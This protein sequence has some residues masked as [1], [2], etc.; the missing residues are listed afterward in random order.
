LP[1]PSTVP[2]APRADMEERAKRLPIL[3]TGA[4]G[5]IGVRLSALLLEAGYT[6]LVFHYREHAEPIAE[7][8]ARHGL[9]PKQSLFR[10]DLTDEREVAAM[11]EQIRHT[12][13]ALY[14]L[15]NLAG[16]SGNAMSW[17]LPVSEFR[18]IVDANLLTTFICCREFIPEMREKGTGRILNISSVVGFTGVAGAVHYC[19]AKAGVVGLTKALALELAPKRVNASVIALGY[20]DVG[21]IETISPADQAPILAKIPAGRFGNMQELAGLVRYLLSDVGTYASGQVYHLNGG[22]YG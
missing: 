3:I 9:D 7:L 14:G 10:A 8:L 4:G 12:R 13:G 5:G 1:D 15:I 22:L 20:F 16:E 21:M 6:N 11:H 17:K 2:A 18:R 19:A